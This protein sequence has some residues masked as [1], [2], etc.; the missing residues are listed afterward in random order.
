M[1]ITHEY[2]LKKQKQKQQARSVQLKT[3]VQTG[4]LE[5]EAKRFI[6]VY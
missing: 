3:F 6:T 2:Q 4:N 5:T 1:C